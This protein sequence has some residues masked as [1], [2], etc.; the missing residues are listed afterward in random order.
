MKCNEMHG[1]LI[2]LMLSYDERL[3]LKPCFNKKE[4]KD[5]SRSYVDG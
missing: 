3:I 5:E 1:N 4:I 2:M